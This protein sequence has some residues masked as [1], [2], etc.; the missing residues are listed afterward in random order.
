DIHDPDQPASVPCTCAARLPAPH[1][2][3]HGVARTRHWQHSPCC[4]ESYFECSR[5]TAH[6][7]Q[8]RQPV[9]ASCPAWLG[10]GSLRRSFL[11]PPHTISLL[12]LHW[13]GMKKLCVFSGT[14]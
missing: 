12:L 8:R 2:S 13:H 10:T 14:S 6:S 7:P 11:F 3:R 5:R 1:G 4:R 9:H